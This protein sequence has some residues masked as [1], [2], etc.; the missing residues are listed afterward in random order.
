MYNDANYDLVSHEVTPIYYGQ[1]MDVIS[2]SDSE[3][4]EDNLYR[5]YSIN[6]M[7]LGAQLFYSFK[8]PDSSNFTFG[9]GAQFGLSFHEHIRYASYDGTVI[10][11]WSGNEFI[12]K[13][14]NPELQFGLS[15]SVNYDL[16]SHF[17]IKGIINSR[18]DIIATEEITDLSIGHAAEYEETRKYNSK[19]SRTSF[20]LLLNYKII[21]IDIFV[22][23]RFY[24]DYVWIKYDIRR[25]DVDDNVNYGDIYNF[26][27][28]GKSFYEL[29]G[30][31]YYKVKEKFG[32]G[33]QLGYGSESVEA[34]CV[35]EYF[36]F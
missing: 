22:G 13:S 5:D 2:Y 36:I 31:V 35:M 11:E 9:I 28:Q 24:Y 3:I 17:S 23:P 12:A 19:Q 4:D 33:G 34:Y 18:L 10:N 1:E 14:D 6:F 15:G 29:Y 8:K 7:T 30:G 21:G 26:K 16:S 20:D 25:L 27:L 32:I